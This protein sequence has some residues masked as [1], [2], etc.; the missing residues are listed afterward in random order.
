MIAHAQTFDEILQTLKEEVFNPFITL[1][2][3]IAFIV[4]I[5]GVIQ[6]MASP[7]NSE[8]REKGKRH[9]LWGMFGIFVMVAVLGIVG[10]IT[11]LFFEGGFGPGDPFPDPNPRPGLPHPGNPPPESRI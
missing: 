5:F 3:A 2:F 1:L 9:L 11:S 4:F 7:E 10:L 6:M 8:S